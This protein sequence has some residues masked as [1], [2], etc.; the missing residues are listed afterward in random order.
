MAAVVDFDVAEIIIARRAL[1]KSIL[2]TFSSDCE[3]V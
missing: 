1:K 2:A 3:A